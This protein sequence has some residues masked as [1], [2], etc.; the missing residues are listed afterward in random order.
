MEKQ[1]FK[2]EHQ[3][4]NWRLWWFG[5]IDSPGGHREIKHFILACSLKGLGKTGCGK[6]VVCPTVCTRSIEPSVCKHDE[7]GLLDDI[8]G[9]KG[10]IRAECMNCGD[11]R[12]A[13]ISK[14]FCQDLPA[15]SG[16]EWALPLAAVHA[17]EADATNVTIRDIIMRP[18]DVAAIKK[19]QH[20]D[21][22]KH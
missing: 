21:S 22:I 14:V 18:I 9:P 4:H 7:Y 15:E 8:D 16:A 10:K 13:K 20:D 6:C 3:E 5:T 2:G 11:S 19:R 1:E 17:C 12:T